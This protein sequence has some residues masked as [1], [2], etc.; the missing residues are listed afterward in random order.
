MILA[1]QNYDLSD[2]CRHFEKKK[3]HHQRKDFPFFYPINHDLFA[4]RENL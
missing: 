2:I 3:E 1:E 4:A